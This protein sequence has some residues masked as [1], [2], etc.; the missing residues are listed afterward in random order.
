MR[1]VAKFI[2][3]AQ[4]YSKYIHHFKLRVTPLWELTIKHEYTNP[5]AGIWTDAC[6]C[7]FDDIWEAIISDPCLLH[8]NHNRLVILLSDFLSKDFGNVVCQPGTDKIPETAMKAYRLGSDFSFMTK[9]SSATI[10]P[11]A[12]GG[13]PY[14]GNEVRLHSHLGKCLPATGL[15][16]RTAICSLGSNLSCLL[17][18]TPHV[19]FCHT[20]A[21]TL[22]SYGCRCS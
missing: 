2:G 7:F 6:Q 9:D 12:F 21:T 8:Y 19:S 22:R 16:T 18:V 15:L 13:C 20:M 14:C 1:D 4:F 11:V 5:V 17:S 10:H 3:F